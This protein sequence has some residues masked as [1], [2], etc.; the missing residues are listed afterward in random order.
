MLITTIN[1]IFCFF[2]STKSK[3]IFERTVFIAAIVAFVFH[4]LA[5]MLANSGILPAEL[6]G[7]DEHQNPIAAIYT[8][9]TIILLYEIY[10]LI[11]YLPKSITI[12]LG[13]Q[14]EIVTL[15]IIRKIFNDL[16]NLTFTNGTYDA[17]RIKALVLTFIGLI[18]M[19]LL[20]FCFYKLRGSKP[21]RNDETSCKTFEEKRFVLIKK[22]MAICLMGVF[23]FLF[24]NSLFDL[25]RI[26]FTVRGIVETMKTVNNTFFF[27]FFTA[28]ILLEVL[29]L[30]STFNLSDKFH[31]VIRN[32]GF[33]ISTIL[34]KLSFRV[35]GRESIILILISIT[36]GVAIMGVHWLY[37]RKG[38]PSQKA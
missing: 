13:K 29:L 32:A 19:M 6:I 26:P 1:R 22:V 28:L 12:Y 2:F 33:V 20:I 31:K 30:L 15:I 34:L 3:K 8:P 4:F 24:I 17:P 27:T 25:H 14:Y 10:L 7:V 9:F 23:I 18:I 16:A 38:F 36:F 35:E 21:A 37:E 5:I 11:Y